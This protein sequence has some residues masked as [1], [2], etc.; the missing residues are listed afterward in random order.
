M[1]SGSY[2]ICFCDLN[3]NEPFAIHSPMLQLL[4]IIEFLVGR[5][6]QLIQMFGQVVWKGGNLPNKF[7]LKI[8]T[9]FL[10]CVTILN[11]NSP[12]MASIW[13]CDICEVLHAFSQ[14]FLL[15]WVESE[16]NT[17]RNDSTI[18]K[19]LY[20]DVSFLFLQLEVP[21]LKINESQ[22]FEHTLN[23]YSWC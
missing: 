16:E 1:P 23:K 9:L 5:V 11:W 14:L 13:Q 18:R 17:S 21:I 6:Q 7:I 8:L 10:V 15:D 22:H 19:E 4:P 20:K 12:Q 3:E 2:V